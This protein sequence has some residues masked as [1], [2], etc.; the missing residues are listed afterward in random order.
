[1]RTKLLC[2]LILRCDVKMKNECNGKL[3]VDFLFCFDEQ[4][5]MFSILRK[6]WLL[7]KTWNNNIEFTISFLTFRLKLNGYAGKLLSSYHWKINQAEKS[8]RG[9]D[10]AISINKIWLINVN[11]F[12]QFQ[13]TCIFCFNEI[14]KLLPIL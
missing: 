12:T 8:S 7:H 9:G 1:M 2:N 11:R 4:K 6:A 13:N 14:L 5:K 3:Q 10:R